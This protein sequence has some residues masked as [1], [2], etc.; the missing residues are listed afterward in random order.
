M[1]FF[2]RI[3]KNIP[4][5]GFMQ[6]MQQ[7]KEQYFTRIYSLIVLFLPDLSVLC[8][9]GHSCALLRVVLRQAGADLQHIGLSRL[10]NHH[11]VVQW[12]RYRSWDLRL[13]LGWL[14]RL[15]LR[16]QKNKTKGQQHTT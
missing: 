15:T 9:G 11:G 12:S 14:L 10:R 4:V 8:E 2:L 3:N 6:G 7:L 13:S 1:T 5:L 16:L